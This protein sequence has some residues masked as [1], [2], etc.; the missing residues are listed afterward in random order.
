MDK[1]FIKISLIIIIPIALTVGF[2]KMTADDLNDTNNEYSPP[3]D[4]IVIKTLENS[5]DKDSYTITIAFENNS[6][7]ILSLSE[8]EL[9][10]D[11]KYDTTGID[12]G[13]NDIYIKGHDL[14]DF[15]EDRKHG[16]DPGETSEIVFKIPKDITLDKEKFNLEEVEVSYN[17]GMYKFRTSNNSILLGVGS[18]GGSETVK[19]DIN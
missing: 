8:T 10:I 2:F 13:Q 9:C 15:T 16:I 1:K 4:D 11:Y 6:K 12:Y 18:I 14:N 7:N 19:L 17:A 3:I 5:E